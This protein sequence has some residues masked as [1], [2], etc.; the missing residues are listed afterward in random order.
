MGAATNFSAAQAAEGLN[1]LAMSGFDAAQSMEMI[2]DV[3]HLAAAGSMDMASAAGYISGAMKGFNDET[4]D[5]VY[6]ADLMAKGATLANTSVS[7]LGEAMASGASGAAAYGQS[8]ESM[9][10]ALLR[11][12]EQGEVGS[13]AGTA[14]AAAMKDLY[15]PSDQA[16]S[17]L[18]ELGVAAYENGQALDFNEI[19]N[20]LSE[21]LSGMSDEEA[22]AYKQTIFGIQGL[23]AFNQMTVT[24]TEKQ[25]EWA[26]ALANA[27]G[28]AS[29]QYDTMTDNLQG[30]LD[31][32]SSAM[33]GLKIAVSD[34]LTPTLR[35]FT[36]F[37]SDSIGKVTAAFKEGGIEGAMDALAPILSDGIAMIT[38][39][40]PDFID[41]GM[42]LL[43]A[44]GQGIM[45]NLP[46]LTQAATEI[47]LMLIQYIIDALPKFVEA[48]IQIVA[49]L[50]NG[51]AE[52]LPTLIPAIVDMVMQIVQALIDNAPLLL[53][54]ALQL[55]TGLAQGLLD[56]LP[57]LI[58]ALPGIITGIIDF[59]LGAIP[60]IIEAGITLLTSLVEALP[61]IIA[62]IV[63]VIPQIITGIVSAVV[64][65]L[66]LIIDA[67]IQ[68]FTSLIKALP[69]IITAVVGAIPQIIEG[70]I[71]AV[72][73]S[74]PL[75]IDAG[76]QLFVALVEALPE[77][78]AAVVE[79]VPQI[80]SA[81]INA[82]LGSLPLIIEAGVKLFVALIQALP[83]IIT[84]I[85]GAIPQI[86][87]A[88]NQAFMGNIDIIMKAGFELFVALIKAL[89]QIVIAIVKAVPEIITGLVKAF[90]ESIGAIIQVGKDLV[91]GIW[92]GIVGAADQFMRDVK[93]F[94]GGIVKGVKDFLGIH[95]PSKLFKE[96]IGENIALGVAEGIDAKAD[97]AI[98]A[99]DDMAKDVYSRSKDW[100]DKQT[101]YM[102]L[103]LDDQIELWET[104]QG[105]FIETSKQYSDA[106][107][108]LYDL[109]KKKR[110]EENKAAEQQTNEYVANIKSGLDKIK[111]LWSDYK[112][113]YDKEYSSINGAFGL[114]ASPN[115][116][117]YVEGV[118]LMENMRKQIRDINQFYDG[119]E[120]LYERGVGKDMVDEIRAMG[121]GAINELVGLLDLSDQQL[122]EYYDMYKHKADVAKYWTD[123]YTDNLKN[124]AEASITGMFDGMNVELND[125]LDA[126]YDW[127]ED[128]VKELAAGIEAGTLSYLNG[129][130]AMIAGRLS[131]A[132]NW[133]G[134]MHVTV[135]AAVG[136]TVEAVAQ[137]VER[138][139]LNA[140]ANRKQVYA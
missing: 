32:L 139:I 122:E 38:E 137:E 36:Q 52:A 62:A 68:L 25:N 88:L 26:D 110:D 140:F 75:I 50:A 41:A 129:S 17:A 106:E 86:I 102:E 95:S 78:I 24:S 83:Q 69:E 127:G 84:T 72:V 23:R 132:E 135:N 40:I 8:A 33:D 94:F 121:P 1:I 82:V 37:A 112:T 90:N 30:D 101:K 99:A 89:P 120:Q 27:A 105:Q 111:K 117:Q 114:F 87:S 29:K 136:Q 42:R 64:E 130:G 18:A 92:Q 74:L 93:E 4:K 61:D 45:D 54:A 76:L 16:A 100:A 22:N 79:A 34:Q 2:E 126:A 128:Y 119:L 19:V 28:E 48:A 49:T 63:E 47:I 131:G 134:D 85:V 60:Q 15:T 14:L 73:E 59:F 20:N 65:N 12:A 107:E 39:K 103:S 113:V 56:A 11:L 138:R 71:T 98:K 116:R 123:R 67:G 91:G 53:D 13:A 9:T 104:I 57:V 133:S 55:I 124:I 58:Q 35:E 10:V 70:I 118:D 44:L 51:I 43:S 7:Q 5:S 66:P 46:Q 80:I 21:A 3:L 31:I 97:K 81:V 6:Y 109:R 125:A 96:Q 115:D 108:K 77:I